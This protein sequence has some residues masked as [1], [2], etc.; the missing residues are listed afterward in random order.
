MAWNDINTPG[1]VSQPLSRQKAIVTGG[2]S[3]IGQAIAVALAHAGSEVLVNYLNDEDG[4]RETI[5]LISAFGGESSIYKADVSDEGAVERMFKHAVEQMGTVDLLLNNAGI[6]KD[7][8]FEMM[9]LSDWQA[10]I[11]VNLT[12]Y[13][14]CARAAV[15]EFLRRGVVPETSSAAGKIL[16]V[17]SVHEVIPWAGRA[18]YAASKGGLTMLMQT[19][20]QE[21]GPKGIRCNSIAPGA[22]RTPINKEVWS[23]PEQLD[24]LLE[25]IPSRR[26]GEVEDV[27]RAAVW[28]ASDESDYVHGTTLFVDGGMTCYP[29]FREGG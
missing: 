14:L 15:R 22:I 13:F 28:L 25:L 5:D 27:A 20:A 11:D 3:G 6:Q 18:N 17:S 12:G 16:F 24:D 10:V 19:L 7:A 4:A 29:G 21:L 23:D 2:S 1:E 26:I 9:S 8:A